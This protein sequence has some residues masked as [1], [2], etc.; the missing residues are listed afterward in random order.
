MLIMVLIIDLLGLFLTR[1]GL[2]LQQAVWCLFF[3]VLSKHVLVAFR[4]LF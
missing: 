3:L 1:I 4:I 2:L